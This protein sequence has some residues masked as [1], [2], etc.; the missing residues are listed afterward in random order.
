MCLYFA[1]N[2]EAI[3]TVSCYFSRHLLEI[4]RHGNQQITKQVSLIL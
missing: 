4:D 3:T 2:S 1:T